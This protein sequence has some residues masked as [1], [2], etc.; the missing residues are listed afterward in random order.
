M[1]SSIILIKKPPL[2][3]YTTATLGKAIMGEGSASLISTSLFLL[4]NGS[5]H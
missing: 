5:L 4:N 2:I 3:F 1:V